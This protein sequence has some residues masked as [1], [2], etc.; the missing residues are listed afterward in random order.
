MELN[1]I[2][3]QKT[4][5]NVVTIAL[6][7]DGKGN[8]AEAF[9]AL[10]RSAGFRF[11]ADTGL[12]TIESQLARVRETH[13]DAEPTRSK[14]DIERPRQDDRQT[15]RTD[16]SDE[17]AAAEK[18][19]N[20]NDKAAKTD[21][22]VDSEIDAATATA[23]VATDGVAETVEVQF[24]ILVQLPTGETAQIAVVDVDTLLAAASQD[25]A[26]AK[27]LQDAFNA[28]LIDLQD[29]SGALGASTGDDLS[30]ALLAT[31][32]GLT[33]AD[34]SAADDESVLTGIFR[35]MV[36]ALRPLTNGAAATQAQNAAAQGT[37]ANQTI[38]E[39]ADADAG[40]EVRS[41]E[42]TRQA[43]QIAQTLDGGAKVKINVI[44]DGR[45]AASMPLSANPFNHFV[46]YNPAAV[47]GESLANGQTGTGDGA[48][49]ADQTN[50]AN[51]G[52]LQTALQGQS[53]AA[54][55]NTPTT[56]SVRFDGGPATKALEMPAQSSPQNS[57]G[58]SS[59]NT[60]AGLMS[61]NASSASN[62]QAP[63]QAAPQTQQQVIE[64]IKVHITR[65]AKAGLDRVTIHLKP[66]ELGR[67]EIKLEMFQ[68]GRVKATIAADNPSTLDMLQKDARGLER[69]LQ[70][71]GL[72]ASADDLEFNLRGDDS[73]RLSADGDDTRGSQDGGESSSAAN[74]GEEAEDQMTFDYEGAARQRGGVDTYV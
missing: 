64:Q 48:A 45:L 29:Q 27:A 15:D 74:G 17:P 44:V 10:M 11:S 37:A 22:G 21:D 70:D 32:A 65:A 8:A 61:Q 12:A 51:T 36:N 6:S 72:R 58:Q 7:T 73:E 50:V 3:A 1:S 2:T 49:R 43:A 56:G 20:E 18:P 31:A 67:I 66:A 13:P 19:R 42:A 52:A 60:F 35:D 55:T 71:A 62:T 25:P 16:D 30:N 9:A 63:A 24:E 39:T 53:S 69:T 54:N 46:G 57:G 5:A 33:D 59:G 28:A 40:L 4:S 14:A 26:F 23:A 38:A 41:S 47:Q 68:D 34:A